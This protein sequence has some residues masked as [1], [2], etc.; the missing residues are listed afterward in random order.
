MM[1]I[2]D[3]FKKKYKLKVDVKKVL[4]SLDI[5][6]KDSPPDYVIRCISGSHSDNN[7]SLHID[8]EEGIFKC[9]SCGYK[10]NMITL[11]AQ[12]LGISNSEAVQRLPV[13]TPAAVQRVVDDHGLLLLPS[14]R[15]FSAQPRL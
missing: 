14:R 12:F 5:P 10:G 6:F 1:S 9:W 7:P 15:D 11:T 4:E 8:Q 2:L 13:A 3:K